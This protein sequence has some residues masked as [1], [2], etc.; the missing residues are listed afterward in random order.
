MD[1][2]QPPNDRE[3][4]ILLKWLSITQRYRSPRLWASQWNLFHLSTKISCPGF[5]SCLHFCPILFP[6]VTAAL[7][8]SFLLL[9]PSFTVWKIPDK[10]LNATQSSHNLTCDIFSASNL[11][12]KIY[13]FKYLNSLRKIAERP[14][15]F[16][17]SFHLLGN[18]F[19]SFF[20]SWSVWYRAAEEC[21]QV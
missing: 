13:P 21:W 10:T 5:V 11:M 8:L 7:H 19:L 9:Y 16:Q 14:V 2:N 6:Y 12:C 17:S 15:W 18:I 20:H 4:K 1:V 3:V